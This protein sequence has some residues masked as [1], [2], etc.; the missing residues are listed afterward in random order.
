MFP[1]QGQVASPPPEIQCVPPQEQVAIAKLFPQQGQEGLP[2]NSSEDI[3]RETLLVSENSLYEFSSI[4][5]APS[6]EK[7]Y[8]HYI[9]PQQKVQNIF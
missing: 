6:A 8:E 9:P 5:Y 1:H 7:K 4:L 2:L 3:L